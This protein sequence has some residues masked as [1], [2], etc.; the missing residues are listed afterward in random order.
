MKS[1]EEIL[2][3]IANEN[4][5]E[6]WGEFMYDTHEHTQN[7]ATIQAM[8]EYAAQDRWVK[9]SERLPELIDGQSEPVLACTKLPLGVKNEYMHHILKGYVYRTSKFW[10]WRED[11]TQCINEITHWQ[12]IPTAPKD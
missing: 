9:V 2:K 1:A 8:R 3:R 11:S 10:Y 5:Y 6:T 12:P 4:S 7:E